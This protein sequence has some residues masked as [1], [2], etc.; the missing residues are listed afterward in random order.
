[1]RQRILDPTTSVSSALSQLHKKDSRKP[2]MDETENHWKETAAGCIAVALL[3]AAAV[4]FSRCSQPAVAEN[5]QPP[6]QP[7]PVEAVMG[8]DRITLATSHN[9]ADAFQI[10]QKIASW[11]RRDPDNIPFPIYDR[12]RSLT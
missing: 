9:H 2:A 11:T 1:M 8:A 4:I 5:T 12:S 10:A 6:V 7:D 3:L